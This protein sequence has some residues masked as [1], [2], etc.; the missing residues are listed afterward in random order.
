M[1]FVNNYKEYG[2]L[3]YKTGDSKY[4]YHHRFLKLLANSVSCLLTNYSPCDFS[5]LLVILRLQCINSNLEHSIL[6]LTSSV[7]S[8]LGS[9]QIGN[10]CLVSPQAS[11]AV[12][13]G[14]LQN[15]LLPHL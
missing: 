8:D 10:L 4:H 3:T 14:V 12:F 15:K 11:V 6:C 2:M 1:I 5:K 7:D 9:S 13:A